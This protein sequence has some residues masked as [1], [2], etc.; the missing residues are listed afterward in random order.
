MIL[1]VSAAD[2]VTDIGQATAGA[3]ACP[4][5]DEDATGRFGDELVVTS[6]VTVGAWTGTRTTALD[7]FST[8]VTKVASYVY[9]LSR[10]GGLLVLQ[11]GVAFANVAPAAL[12][13][14]QADELAT[15]LA[16]RLGALS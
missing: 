12:Y 1:E 3:R 14:Q 8:G 15:K 2:T 10:S 16:Q 7:T 6:S 9:F 4:A 5:H 13:Q 11:L